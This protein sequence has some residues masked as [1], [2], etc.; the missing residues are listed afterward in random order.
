MTQAA[1]A[2]KP[3][4]KFQL[5]AMAPGWGAVVMGTSVISTFFAELVNAGIFPRTSVVLRFVFLG[6]A[7]LLGIVVVAGLTTRF[8][9]YPK[10]ALADLENPVKG[11]MAAT[12]AGVFLTLAVS[13]GR[14]GG[15]K[16]FGPATEAIVGI[17]GT[18]GG[19]LALVTGWLYLAGLFAKGNV[20]PRMITG[21]MLIPPVVTVIT[22]VALAPLI[23]PGQEHSLEL[24]LISWLMLGI[25]TVLYL[26]ISAVLVYRSLT[27]E[28]PPPPLAPSLFIGVGPA[29]LIA[30]DI[31]ALTKAASRLGL[32]DEATAMLSGF[33]AIGMW[34][35]GL[36][37]LVMSLMIIARGYEKVPFGLPMWAFTFPL[38]AWSVGG[39]VL[40]TSLGSAAV[41]IIGILGGMALLVT[42]L[43]FFVRTIKG[44]LTGTIFVE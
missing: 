11:G 26:L 2:P 5:Q 28:L 34:G 12:Y 39:I 19:A 44:V 32:V 29:G 21:A 20:N 27:V 3:A 6:I 23:Q 9:L 14:T 38:G 30:L 36:A 8:V 10:I 25:G 7:L 13:I 31:M 37:W 18:I 43:V 4:A 1:T 40:G 17:F 41:L 15:G 33:V 35:F 16:V 24:L 42:W 22:P